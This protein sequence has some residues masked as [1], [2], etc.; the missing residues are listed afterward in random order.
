M[1]EQLRRWRHELHQIPEAGFAEHGTAAYVTSVLDELGV[2]HVTGVGGTGVVATITGRPTGRRVGLR[3]D[4]DAL[5]LEETPGRPH[6]SRHDGHM[7]ACGHD[8]HMAML[9]GAAA[10]LTRATDLDGTVDLVFQPAEE[11]GRGAQAMIDDGLFDRFPIASMF[12]LHNLPGLPAGDLHTR[13][14]GIM[15]SEDNFTITITGQGG[16]AA[17]PHM[18]T[19][20]LVIAAHVILG[21]QTIV[22]RN[23][24]PT[25][26][27]VVSC[28]EI[29]TDG[30]R[31]AIPTEVVITGDTRAFDPAVQALLERRIRELATGIC[32]AH[33][34]TAQVTYT[35]EFAVTHNDP[36]A[37][38]LAV[39]AALS[40]VG[41]A[42]VE[43]S[44]PPVMPSE[45]FGVYAQHVPANFTFIGNGVDPHD[46]GTP[47]HSRDY[48][49]NDAI[50]A[51]GA[52][53]LATVARR[54]LARRDRA[55]P[56]T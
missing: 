56:Q 47:L 1:I 27:A 17:R 7:H 12:G 15:A 41:T 10:H 21:L 25:L 13:P 30:T 49:F 38:D 3:A 22:S 42:R 43:P 2:S 28:T 54:A 51:T 32:A 9:L 16:H 48:D 52:T 24:D 20:P 29:T 31:N 4:M 39:T 40:T 46:G 33:A 14:G 44:C 37:T 18:V 6:G 45:D 19:D 35:H 5:T 36:A 23:L 11:P 50:T 34:A 53:Y 8:G 55:G 26:P